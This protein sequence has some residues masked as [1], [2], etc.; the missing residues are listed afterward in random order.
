MF[1]SQTI[2]EKLFV[3]ELKEKPKD[4]T[5]PGLGTLKYQGAMPCTVH[6]ARLLI[7]NDTECHNMIKM[8][9]NNDS[10]IKNA[11][12]AGYLQGGIDTCQVGLSIFSLLLVNEFIYTCHIQH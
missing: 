10:L 2:F 11:F 12:C 5:V 4:G 9:G 6:E 7:Y 8:T 1:G 3:S